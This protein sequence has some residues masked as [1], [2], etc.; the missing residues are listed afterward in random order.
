MKPLFIL[1]FCALLFTGCIQEE[2][3][4]QPA[5]L[6]TVRA[7]E[8]FMVGEATAEVLLVEDDFW[9]RCCQVCNCASSPLTK[10]VIGTDTLT[11]LDADLEGMFFGSTFDYQPRVEYNGLTITAQN[12]RLGT[13]EERRDPADYEVDITVE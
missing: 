13:C 9:C 1:L 5:S 3:S 2:A 11:L 7:G 4:L 6:P 12:Y 8:V 10:L